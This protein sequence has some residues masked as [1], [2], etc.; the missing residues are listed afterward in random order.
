MKTIIQILLLLSGSFLA[1]EIQLSHNLPLGSIQPVRLFRLEVTSG[2][3]QTVSTE[4]YYR[5]TGSSV[6]QAGEMKRGSLSNPVYEAEL[7]LSGFSSGLDY[8]FLL[9]DEQEQQH[10]LPQSEPETHPFYLPPLLENFSQEF[11]L[12]SPEGTRFTAGEELLIAV[13]YF[14]LTEEIKPGSVRFFQN[15]K[16]IT[17]KARISSN[18]LVYQSG[19]LEPGEYLMQLKAQ[20]RDGRE[21]LSPVWQFQVKKS[22]DVREKFL[23]NGDLIMRSQTRRKEIDSL[24]YHRT[25]DRYDLLLN[26]NGSYRQLRMQ[27]RIF[28][29]SLENKDRQPVNRY[30]LSFAIPHWQFIAGDHSPQYGTFSVANKNI[31]GLHSDL[32]FHGFRLLTSWGNSR[33]SINGKALNDSLSFEA[34]SAGTFQRS[35]LA[36]RLELGSESGML[37]GL[38][39]SKAKDKISSLSSK[40]YLSSVDSLAMSNPNDNVVLALDTRIALFQ[41]RFIWGAEAAIS[42]Y[43]DNII[44]GAISQDSLETELGSSIPFDPQDFTS[45]FIINKN[46]EPIIPGLSSMAYRTYLRLFLYQNLLNVSYT[47]IGAS[48]NS[49]AASYLPRD[50][51]ILSIMDNVTLLQN[52]LILN[53]G[54]NLISDNVYEEKSATAASTSIYTQALYRPQNLPYFGLGYQGSFSSNDYTDPNSS[55]SL[56]IS[57][58]D[59]NSFS[60]NFHTGYFFNNWRSMPT[61]LGFSFTTTSYRDDAR[62]AFN[63]QRNTVNLNS[64]TKFDD[65]PL[66][67]T[68]SYT[69]S[70]NDNS[71]KDFEPGEVRSFAE[72]IAKSTMNSFYCKGQLSF[73]SDKFKPYADMRYT[74]LAGSSGNSSLLFNLGH[75]WQILTNTSFSSDL[76]IVLNGDRHDA[77]SSVRYYSLKFKLKYKF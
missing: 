44:G 73:L 66:T 54:L 20:G 1:A 2:F 65:L 39:F 42:L 60:L 8:F 36:A 15:G 51:R 23:Y 24:D 14:A 63:F 64:R 5:E 71:V 26:L 25:T 13:S 35:N 4:I 52:R 55:D 38:T 45:F 53:F 3:E 21:I 49:L 62:D 72:D 37:W 75:D 29:S 57:Y 19:K 74:T 77:D 61:E 9:T 10:S 68:A 31:R 56:S 34:Y 32:H 70:I 11:L 47:A 59:L 18:M 27:S 6:F 28:L 22:R 76:G 30:R 41:Q 7:D 46:V 58:Y 33:R 40:Y 67:L 43:N 16:D 48:F 17:L 69:L 12:L 50:T